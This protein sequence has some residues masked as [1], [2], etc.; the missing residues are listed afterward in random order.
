VRGLKI[1]QTTSFFYNG[2]TTSS[3]NFA[4]GADLARMEALVLD[5]FARWG[6]NFECAVGDVGWRMYRAT[7][8]RPNDNIRLWQDEGGSLIGFAWLILN[9]DVDLIVHPR[10]WC[11]TLV[12]EMLAWAERRC[13]SPGGINPR[14][15]MVAW[16][17]KSNAQ[18]TDALRTCGYVRNGHAYLHLWRSLAGEIPAPTLPP[19]YS[20][21]A[22]GGPSEAEARA[23]LHLAAFSHSHISGDMYAR[24]MK[25]RH[26]R[27]DLDIVTVAPEGGLAS[28]ALAWLDAR[29]KAGELEPVGT[30]PAHRRQ[31]LAN[32]AILEAL[33]RLKKLGAQSV[34]VYADAS[35]TA[36]VGLYQQLGFV[37]I[38]ENQGYHRGERRPEQ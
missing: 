4:D 28:M 8:V 9:G 16:S 2:M 34:I 22:I 11:A 10:L 1:R 17:L 6:P 24:L 31:G 13:T 12:P 25:S 21:R 5:A 18:L 38:D 3:R 33:R 30:H 19:R 27:A 14:H 7:T 37:V 36:S 29:S 32:A 15:K 35:N 26:Y 20:L 23:R